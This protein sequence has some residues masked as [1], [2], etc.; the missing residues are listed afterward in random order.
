MA[1]RTQWRIRV[2]GAL[3]LMTIQTGL[4]LEPDAGC[5]SAVALA[6][7]PVFGNSVQCWQSGALVAAGAIWRCCDA[8]RTMGTM[9]IGA[10][11]GDVVM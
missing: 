11:A 3:L 10:A 1:T 5:M 7:R 8:P 4:S 2:V 9:A 6:A